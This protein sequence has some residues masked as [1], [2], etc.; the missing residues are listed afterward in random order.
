MF[1]ARN[2]YSPRRDSTRFCVAPSLIE[3]L[4]LRGDTFFG[5]PAIPIRRGHSEAS[6]LRATPILGGRGGV[7]PYISF[8]SFFDCFFFSYRVESGT[9]TISQI[10]LS[11]IGIR[12]R[13]NFLEVGVAPVLIGHTILPGFSCFVFFSS[14]LFRRGF[15]P[16]FFF[17]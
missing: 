3:G 5:Q 11:Y 1:L 9:V 8:F 15:S 16:F 12:S 4:R 7:F 17:F 13:I 10:Y 14:S 6:S 2:S